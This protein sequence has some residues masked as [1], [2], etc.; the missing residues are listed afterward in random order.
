MLAGAGSQTLIAAL[1]TTVNT[2]PQAEIAQRLN[3]SAQ[4]I[5]LDRALL[6]RELARRERFGAVLA[7]LDQTHPHLFSNTAVFITQATVARMQRVIDAVEAAVAC[8]PYQDAALAYA[9]PIARHAAPTRGVFMGYDFHLS[10]VG[11]QLIEINTNAGGAMLNAVLGAAQRAC[12]AEAE[13]LHARPLPSEHAE[14]E[15]L[16]MFRREWQL[17][18]GA[19]ALKTIA[20]VDDAPK[21]QFLYPEFLL[22]QALFERAGLNAVIVD[23]KDLILA[24]GELH[25]GEKAID[26]VYNRLT[27]FAL[28]E[29]AHEMLR[30]AYLD[31][32]VVLTPHPRA[33]ALFADK[34]NLCLLTDEA[35]MA[36]LP[37]SAEHKHAL[38]SGIPRTMT[39]APEMATQL[40]NT[41]NQWFF[42]PAAGYGSRAAYRGA[43]VTKSVFND[44][45]HGHYVAQ[46]L[47]PPAE[48]MV[49][50]DAGAKPL[51][52][53]IRCYVYDGRVQLLAARLYH[54]QTT[55]F[56][57]PQGGF[58]PVFYPD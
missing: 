39:I 27:D 47:V 55:N 6:K 42:K 52:F 25:D 16:A 15:F 54:G 13:Q 24:E 31:N 18:R 7:Q 3:Q 40:W 17:Q 32:A 58:A 36:T 49:A 14:D 50:T 20:I 56:R 4:C 34:R 51:K 28:D 38:R 43:K 41:R 8:P 45:M 11:P 5:T 30:R 48:R 33:H 12:C 2:M 35:F 23:S 46:Q 21:S 44:I 37:I 10:S 22:F 57:T 53:D 26:L 29:P 1:T 19:R 9:P